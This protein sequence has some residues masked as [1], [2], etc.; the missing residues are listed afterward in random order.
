MP[1]SALVMIVRNEEHCIRRCLDS[2]RPYVDAM[3]VVDTGST[4]ETAVL[5]SQAGAEVHHFAWCDDFSAA[6]NAALDHSPADWNLVLDADEWIA[7][8]GEALSRA[9][10]AACDF[11]GLIPV[12][13][14]FELQGRP[15]VAVSWMPRLLPRGVR[16]VGRIHEQPVS[17]H[18]RRRVPVQVTHDGYRHE[19]LHK[20]KGRNRSLLL[21]ML[22]TS[23]ADAYLHYQL[24]R[25]Y[26]VYG[27]F[28]DAVSAYVEAL[29]RSSHS[30]RFRHDLVVRT[31]YSLKR[32]GRYDEAVQFADQEM[33]NWGDSPD[34]YFALGDLLLDCATAN[35]QQALAQWLP[36]AEASW[37]RCLEIGEKPLLEGSV[38]GR[39]SFL[40][41][42]NLAVLYEGLG[43]A[44]KA[45]HYR[46]MAQRLRAK[47]SATP[48]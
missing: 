3:I 35:P 37:L 24:G 38:R 5:A 25:D 30:D 34:F 2:V 19:T 28:D 8:G 20:K 7:G 32:L 46:G 44:Q 29:G 6:R 43:D 47:V 39:G 45:S 26:E 42:H 48:G 4:D 14:E 33:P 22:A 41:A 17:D 10:E 21:Q 1:S 31:L 27:E 16:Y 15:E 13:S 12:G 18:P 23:P 36:M 11:V 9:T 40:A